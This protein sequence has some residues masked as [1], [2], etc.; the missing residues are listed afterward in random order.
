MDF[1]EAVVFMTVAKYTSRTS[2]LG[3]SGGKSVSPCEVM[4]Q[5]AGMSSPP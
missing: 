2:I 5:V 4:L 1:S 3:L